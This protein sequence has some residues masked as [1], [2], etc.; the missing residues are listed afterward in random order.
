MNQNIGPNIFRLATPNGGR[1]PK[2]LGGPPLA[3]LGSPP[4]GLSAAGTGAPSLHYEVVFILSY[5]RKSRYLF[6]EAVASA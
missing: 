3:A 1:P 4:A 5:T 6:P 2:A